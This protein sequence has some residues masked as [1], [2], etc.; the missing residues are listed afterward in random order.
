[1]TSARK[2]TTDSI[3]AWIALGLAAAMAFTLFW[4]VASNP[5]LS[6]RIPPWDEG[7]HGF[8]SVAFADAFLNLSPLRFAKQLWVSS[9]W[10]PVFPILGGVLTAIFGFAYSVPRAFVG[11]LG[12]LC[13]ILA[14]CIGRFSGLK[15]GSAAGLT[16]ALLI[17]TSPIFQGYSTVAMLEVPGVFFTLVCLALFFVH[18]ETGK[19]QFWHYTC[20]AGA[21]LFLAKYNYGVMWLGCLF[22]WLLLQEANLGT[23]IRRI[24]VLTF[25]QLDP[26]S[27]FQWFMALYCALLLGIQ[28]SGGGEWDLGGQKVIL[29]DIWGNPIY[30]FAFLLVAR[31]ALFRRAQFG[32]LT[33]SLWRAP[34]PWGSVVRYTVTPIVVWLLNPQN[35]STCIGALMN[36][37]NRQSWRV[38]L[39][40]YPTAFVTEHIGHPIAGYVCFAALVWGWVRWRDLPKAVQFI[41]FFAS[42]SFLAVVI[43]PNTTSRYLLTVSPIMLT[44][45]AL[46]AWRWLGRWT[47]TALL[48]IA[49]AVAFLTMGVNPLRES[50]QRQLREYTV[51]EAYA[52]IFDAMCEGMKGTTV[53]TVLG[54]NTLISP[55]TVAWRCYQMMEPKRFAELPRT[56]TRHQLNPDHVSPEDIV[57]SRKIE[58]FAVLRY[59]NAADVRGDFQMYFEAYPM[60]LNLLSRS[61]HYRG[62]A[63]T[64]L[65]GG[66]Y[67]LQTFRLPPR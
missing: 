67:Q 21:V 15:N 36:G 4:V 52:P 40:Y 2:L 51:T 59:L 46:I 54:L 33:R 3:L 16:A 13:L 12:G 11:A 30:I 17:L 64:D 31:N 44:A 1:M 24:M 28:F 26:R 32:A 66:E 22:L 35:F 63:I 39:T 6:T 47:V 5:E 9:Y 29:H 56:L 18:A 23:K 7:G 57:G 42:L 27:P 50:V 48:P 53:N 49:A 60:I 10:P 14:F 45:G 19:E 38:M 34:E 61:T 8:D 25:Q 20:W 65:P 37:S 43:H 55:D 58:T 41:L 62:S